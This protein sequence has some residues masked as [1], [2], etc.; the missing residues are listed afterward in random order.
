MVAAGTLAF[1][2]CPR[3]PS[4]RY[5]GSGDAPAA[6]ETFD[7]SFLD[8]AYCIS[9][10]SRDD[11]ATQAAEEFHRVGLCR[12]VIFCRP[13]KEDRT[14][15]KNIW[16]S[17]RFVAQH[18]RS[19]RGRRVLILEDDV[20][21]DPRLAP[22]T[23]REV[24]DAVARL[25]EGWM[26]L[27]LGHWP[28]WSYATDRR[29]VRTSSLC[30]HAYIASGR[31]LLWI[32]RSHCR[33]ETEP[34]GS[35]GERLRGRGIDAAFSTL[36]RMYAFHPMI[37]FQRRSENDHVRRGY[38]PGERSVYATIK[39]SR[40]YLVTRHMRA[41]EVVA[42]ALSPLA[43]VFAPRDPPVEPT[44]NARSRS[45]SKQQREADPGS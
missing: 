8:A 43:R 40:E 5:C 6:D 38:Q 4:C 20:I 19:T 17:H 42:L 18:A 29:I 35:L 36:P 23:V 2:R 13:V 34:T 7:W 28:I 41:A 39:N 21:F 12:H 9:L 14:P 33:I 22:A 31:L 27:F 10:Q 44:S 15:K 45:G 37:A 24:G 32:R 25:P 16:R 30:T 11:R 26:G 3:D 1:H